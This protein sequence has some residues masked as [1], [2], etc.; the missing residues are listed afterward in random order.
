M[1]EGG[2]K[3]ERKMRKDRFLGRRG[4]LINV[5]PFWVILMANVKDPEP[6][7]GEVGTHASTC[8]SARKNTLSRL[9]KVREWGGGPAEE[10][11]ILKT[12]ITWKCLS[13]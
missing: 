5:I 8:A 12:V 7:G 2:G 13:N 10:L 9:R 4:G 1:E 6:G 11:Y 3:R